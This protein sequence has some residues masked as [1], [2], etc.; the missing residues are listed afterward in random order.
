MLQVYYPLYCLYPILTGPNMMD[1]PSNIK[2][3]N[4]DIKEYDEY[5]VRS[6]SIPLNYIADK[7]L[8]ILGTT[9][10][11]GMFYQM[12]L[13]KI[14]PNLSNSIHHDQNIPGGGRGYIP[15]TQHI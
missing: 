15:Q 1:P 13:K 7:N 5:L 4:S 3:V 2:Q 14:S 9:M 8:E 12:L 6:C 10:S 11:P